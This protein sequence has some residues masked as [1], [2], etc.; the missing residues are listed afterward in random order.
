MKTYWLAL[1]DSSENPSDYSGLSP[2]F[3]TFINASGGTATPPGITEA[4]SGSGVY[5]F[6]YG[7]TLGI[8]FTV[9]WGATTSISAFRYTTGN[10]D[11][12]QAVDQRVGGILDNNDSI[13][14]T[15]VDP[16]TVIGFLK[17]NLEW[18]EGNAVYT[19]SSG[20]WAVSSRGSSTLLRE[21]TLSDDSSTSEK[22]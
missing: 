19:K 9:D 10:L 1:G 4:I 21:K 20:N 11:P 2:T 22:S 17:R 13:G 6:E 7:P 16:T 3:I 14:S 18:L 12:I 15:S 5:S 8:F